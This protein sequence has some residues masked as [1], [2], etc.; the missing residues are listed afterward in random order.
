MSEVTSFAA[1][2]S[3][4]LE[5]FHRFMATLESLPPGL[6]Q[7]P[8]VCGHW[9]AKQI[10]A[11][12]AGWHYEAVR[13]FAAIATGDPL[14]KHYDVDSFNALQVEGRGHLSW[15]LTLDDLRE[16]V[17]ILRMQAMDVPEVSAVGDF[18]YAEWLTILAQEFDEHRAQIVALQT[19]ASSE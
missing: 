17:D 15:D 14:H 9:N 19:S 4:W 7:T 1:L 12:L 10:V 13:R 6:R 2:I 8:G 16:V 18:R 3:R 5:S 11:H